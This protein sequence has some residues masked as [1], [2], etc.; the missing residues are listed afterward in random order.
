MK[1]IKKVCNQKKCEHKGKLQ[2]ITNFYRDMR[3]KDGRQNACK[4]CVKK[5]N[6]RPAS[7][8][9]KMSAEQQKEYV[10]DMGSV[11][12]ENMRLKRLT[13]YGV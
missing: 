3:A 5:R 10:S 7:F 4:D 6:P 8:E 2:T 1:A 12:K 9:P 13:L 11:I